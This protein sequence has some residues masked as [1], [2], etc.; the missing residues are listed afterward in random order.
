M[1]PQRIG[2]SKYEKRRITR[3]QARKSRGKLPLVK[4]LQIAPARERANA[5]GRRCMVFYDSGG[6]VEVPLER[7]GRNLQGVYKT[8]DGRLITLRSDPAS[9]LL[10]NIVVGELSLVAGRF[11]ESP[12]GVNFVSKDED[13]A[14]MELDSGLRGQGLGLKAASKAERHVRS[15]KSGKHEF[16]LHNPGFIDIFK[17]LGY[18]YRD[19]F[20]PTLRK[21]GKSRYFDD[22]NKFHR[23]EAIDPRT[24]KT[25]IFTFLIRPQ[26]G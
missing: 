12:M 26:K 6:K 22:I 14:H 24:K 23:I 7:Y 16:E 17:K 13:L 4:P 5:L 10:S 1:A 3:Q 15:G 11:F 19:G 20:W 25:R 18:A 21:S 8:H 2:L 9:E